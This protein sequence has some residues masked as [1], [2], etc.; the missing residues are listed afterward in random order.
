MAEFYI[1]VAQRDVPAIYSSFSPQS[2]RH[3]S[4]FS[5]AE[6]IKTASIQIAMTSKDLPQSMEFVSYEHALFSTAA[7]GSCSNF[8]HGEC[9]QYFLSSH[10]HNELCTLCENTEHSLRQISNGSPRETSQGER[11]SC[12][13]GQELRKPEGWPLQEG[14]LE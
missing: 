2:P 3:I 9:Y 8:G 10:L 6:L 1:L 13:S 12:D 11:G 14:P 4:K 7:N 5:S